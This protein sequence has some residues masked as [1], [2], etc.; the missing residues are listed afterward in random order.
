[1]TWRATA[2]I[3]AVVAA[4]LS[5]RL[6]AI[7][8]QP[9]PPLPPSVHLQFEPPPGSVLGAGE[10]TL[11][12]A[13][14][15]AGDEVV[16]VATPGGSARLWRRPLAAAHA[17]AIAGTE[18]ASAPSWVTGQHAVS[19]FVGGTLNVVALDTGA[20]TTAAATS[21]TRPAAPGSMTARSWSDGC[22]ARWTAGTAEDGAGHPP[23]AR[24]RRPSVSGA[25]RPGGVG[26]CRRACG[27]LARGTPLVRRRRQRPDAEPMDTP[28]PPLAGCSTRAVAHCWPSASNSSTPAHGARGRD[29]GGRRRLLHRPHAG[30]RVSADRARRMPARHRVTGWSGSTTTARPRTR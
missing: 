2:S 6:V 7:W 4:V 14:S 1:M 28:S 8:R 13:A 25:R 21:S 27:R 26:I 15:P 22:A 30:G 12:A 9:P 19:F 11:D 23:P 24:R 5:W 18:G 16:F 10:D 29:R 20:V 3:L 17:D